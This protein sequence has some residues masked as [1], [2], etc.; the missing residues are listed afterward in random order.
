M[1]KAVAFD[2][3]GLMFNTEDI[4]HEAGVELMR[5]HGCEMTDELFTLIMGRRAEEGYPLLVEAA[6]LNVDPMKLWRESHDLF[7]NMLDELIEPMP[8]LFELLDH[9]ERSGLPKGVATSSD[10]K[11]LRRILTRFELLDRFQMTLTAEDVTNGKP[12]PEIYLKA[13]ARL[14]VDSHEMLVLEDSHNGTKAAAAAGAHIISVPHRYSAHQDF[15][16]ARHV[17]SSLIDPIVLGLLG[18]DR[19]PGGKP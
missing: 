15:S 11:Y 3:D 12:H 18:G 4:F 1:I 17:A 8:G 2:L 14:G 5:R 19:S 9:I 16:R 10:S 7:L 13:A 6:G